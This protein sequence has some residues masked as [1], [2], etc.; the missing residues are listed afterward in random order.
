MQIVI[1]TAGS[2]GDVAPFTGLGQRLRQDGHKVAL[3]AHQPFAAL[4]RGSGLEY[5]LLPGDPLGLIRAR[6]AATSSEAADALTEAFLGDLGGGVI[7][8]AGGADVL[9]TAFG[10]A[11]LSR[12]AGEAMGIPVIGTYLAPA[13][14]TGEFLLP[15][16]PQPTRPGR[17]GNL[18]AGR[19]LLRQAAKR[20]E[21]VLARLR[22]DLGLR[23]SSCDGTLGPAR[24]W[25]VCHGFSPAVIPR[26]ANWAPE[27]DAAGYWWPAMPRAWRPPDALI[28]FLQ[29]G[30]PPVFIGFGS[31]AP[32]DGKWLG[33]LIS[34][35]VGR[36]G[37]RAVVQ[38]GWAGLAPQ[39]EDLLVIGD[40]PHEWLFPGWRRWCTTPARAR[41]R[42]ACALVYRR[43]PSR[44]WPISRS[45]RTGCTG[46]ACPLSQ[47]RSLA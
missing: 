10:P 12:P 37:V 22:A 3:A 20:Y 36:A 15:G 25:P 2:R 6:S 45:G 11:P 17:R 28:S 35:P 18:E 29:A 47:S 4:V 46:S 8:A 31:M 5:R 38:A 19:A 41:Q 39:G 26:P 44:S 21:R 30:P 23:G 24:G 7:A 33:D 16:S 34:A 27:A 9:L 14:P 43:L 13:V 40:V 42:R 32:T 1:V